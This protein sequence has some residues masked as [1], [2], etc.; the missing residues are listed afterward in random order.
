MKNIKLMYS[1]MTCLLALVFL[2]TISCDRDLSEEAEF[3]DFAKTSE[4]FIEAPIGL[5]TDFY[6]PF[7]GS[8]ATAWSV[9]ESEGYESQVSMRFDVPNA[10]DPEGSYAG[11]IFR[12]D[13]SGR[14][15]TGYD[16]LTF[17]AKASQG[18]TIGE[19]GFG[20]DFEE[21]KYQTTIQNTSLSTSWTK[22]IIPI[23]DPS[24]LIEERGM[25]WY[26]A[27]TQETGGLGYT[28]WIDDLKF[29]KLGTLGTP[30]PSIGEDRT[31]QAFIGTNTV[32]GNRSVIFNL[33]SGVNQT[34]IPALSYFDWSSSDPSVVAVE[35]FGR[36]EMISNGMSVITAT[37]AGVQAT[38]A[39]TFEV[40]GEFESAPIP[41]ARDPADVISIFS[42]AYNDVP[43]D[44]YNGYFA[45][46]QTTQGQD[47]IFVN[48][49]RVINYTDL[50]FVG[51]GTFVDVS[52]IN[53]NEMTHFHVDINVR[54]AI[55]AGDFIR[56]QLINNVG[57]VETSGDITIDGSQFQSEEWISLDIPLADFNG[58][59]VR[60]E[61]GLIF[62]ISDATISNI[63]VDNVYYYKE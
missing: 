16:A 35:D 50:N 59:S 58:L 53:A 36:I 52:P 38:G 1:K 32:V 8:K 60:N 17:W 10:D 30:V 33:P 51:I 40:L 2:V 27:G 57:G 39:V 34:V 31:V 28:F 44:Y 47:D 62:F 55:Q 19:L 29:E 49:D 43:V 63:Y 42:N 25:F 5:G 56:L 20:T 11:A 21:N 7:S 3:A 18:V 14:D 9:D 61:L 26:S 41:P 15:L 46:F 12:I 48:G 24:K 45:P 4:I 54:E 22:Y 37:M 13:G 6:F 23:P